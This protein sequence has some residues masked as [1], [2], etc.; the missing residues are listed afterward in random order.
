MLDDEIKKYKILY[1]NF[2]THVAKLHNS[3]LKF[4]ENK[5]HQAYREV[6]THC[7][8]GSIIQKSMRDVAKQIVKEQRELQKEE[9]KRLKEQRRLKGHRYITPKRKKREK[10]DSDY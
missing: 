2:I 6:N 8:Q 10:N 7:L 5:S 4:L 1:S 9:L 3:H